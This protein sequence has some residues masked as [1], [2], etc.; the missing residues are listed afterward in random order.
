[1]ISRK[2]T[3]N[4]TNKIH[5][6]KFKNPK[7]WVTWSKWAAMSMYCS[8]AWNSTFTCC[9]SAATQGACQGEG[10]VFN[11]FNLTNKNYSFILHRYLNKRIW[12][13]LFSIHLDEYYYIILNWLE[14]SR[15]CLLIFRY[16]HFF[17][18]STIWW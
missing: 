12:L 15:L 8:E 1:M 2:K 16:C 18:F 6:H 7:W 3:L 11:F 4:M 17:F 9:S 14:L 10:D 13:K 5:T